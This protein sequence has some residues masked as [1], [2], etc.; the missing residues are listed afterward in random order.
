MTEDDWMQFAEQHPG[1]TLREL[2]SIKD[3]PFVHRVA[4]LALDKD[5]FTGIEKPDDFAFLA[6]HQNLLD[7]TARRLLNSDKKTPETVGT[8]E[9]EGPDFVLNNAKSI[10]G[11]PNFE[12]YLREAAEKA[13]DAVV[14]KNVGYLFEHLPPSFAES[15]L[16][17]SCSRAQEK[18]P[19]TII[20][21]AKELRAN[22]AHLPGVE[23][24]IR[25]AVENMRKSPDFFWQAESVVE[26]LLEQDQIPFVESI[27]RENPVE[28]YKELMH[29]GPKCQEII[30]ASN[31]P[32]A[33]FLRKIYD[34]YHIPDAIR[35]KLP[36]LLDEFVFNKQFTFEKAVKIAGNREQLLKAI[37]QIT[38]R[39]NYLGRGS[40][41]AFLSAPDT[42]EI[43][44][45]DS[46]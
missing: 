4:E 10:E 16:R 31:S 14:I 17:N 25:R 19:W 12:S 37:G 34:A 36:L 13:Q 46:L 39:R 3:A 35:E 38:Q 8:W 30:L 28:A 2:K 42:N 6:D 33:I 9:G 18:E 21:N 43:A 29:R 5:P 11:L 32:E 24:V 27:L 20:A 26:A 23:L 22:S 45:P 40:I 41:G 1:K 15:I 44:K 7:R